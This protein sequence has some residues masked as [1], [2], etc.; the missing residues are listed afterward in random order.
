MK[1]KGKGY[2]FKSAD[3]VEAGEDTVPV[4]RVSDVKVDGANSDKA[5]HVPA[6]KAVEGFE[7]EKGDQLIAMSG[8]TTGKVL[9]DI[10]WITPAYQESARW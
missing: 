7:I 5:N 10:K 1:L 2:A 6:C 4:I 9:V 8:A 3:D